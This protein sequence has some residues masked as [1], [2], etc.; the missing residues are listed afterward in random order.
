M[1]ASL[2]TLKDRLVDTQNRV[3]LCG[4][5]K[6]STSSS[7]P[8]GQ[9]SLIQAAL[10]AP[11][12]MIQAMTPTCRKLARPTHGMRSSTSMRI[13][14]PPTWSQSPMIGRRLLLG[15]KATADPTGRTACARVGSSPAREHPDVRPVCCVVRGGRDGCPQFGMRAPAGEGNLLCACIARPSICRIG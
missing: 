1:R 10:V 6:N 14:Y 11:P 7:C 9:R 2:A 3:V 15:L 5:S 12:T 13:R 8:T 4:H